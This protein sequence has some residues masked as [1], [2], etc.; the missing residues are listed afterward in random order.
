MGR[1]GFVHKGHMC[2]RWKQGT[3]VPFSLIVFRIDSTFFHPLCILDICYILLSKYLQVTLFFENVK[4]LFQNKRI[5]ESKGL[6]CLRVKVSKFWHIF[7]VFC[8]KCVLFYLI[9]RKNRIINKTLA[10]Q[11]WKFSGKRLTF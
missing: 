10:R 6:N 11:A 3:H 5:K 8:F 7:K 2:W 4:I 9:F 1:G